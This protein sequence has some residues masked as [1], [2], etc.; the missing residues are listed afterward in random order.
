MERGMDYE[1]TTTAW[2]KEP[3]LVP[4][5]GAK[6]RFKVDLRSVENFTLR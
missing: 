3:F 4:I 6:F 2:V 5:S 1:I